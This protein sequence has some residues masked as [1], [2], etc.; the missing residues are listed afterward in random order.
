MARR[1]NTLKYIYQINTTWYAYLAISMY[2][3]LTP[4]ECWNAGMPG[5]AYQ[6]I[7]SNAADW[8]SYVNKIQK[9]YTSSINTWI[10]L[11]WMY[12]M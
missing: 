5:M 3:F 11:Q 1:L 12:V 9:I 7:K 2:R 10:Y 8:P 6:V 4:L